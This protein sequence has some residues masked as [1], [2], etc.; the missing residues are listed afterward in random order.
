MAK[1]G[2]QFTDD[3]VQVS[4]KTS[5]QKVAKNGAQFADDA[6]QAGAKTS[7]QEVAKSG[8]QVVDDEAEASLKTA[9]NFQKLIAVIDTCLVMMDT[10]ELAF[11][12]MDLV[13]HKGSDAAKDLRKGSRRSRMI[14]YS[15][16]N[17]NNWNSSNSL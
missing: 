3:A 5:T 16:W 6:I 12:I 17:S 7:T 9:G 8:A 14:L 10:K 11:T 15:N 1:N 13:Q 4:A 2:A